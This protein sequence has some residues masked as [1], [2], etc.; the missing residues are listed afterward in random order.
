ME[1]D[2]IW[3]AQRLQKSLL[4]SVHWKSSII[5][6]QNF[7]SMLYDL[8]EQVDTLQYKLQLEF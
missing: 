1:D 4:K 7:L 3:N 6:M 8:S 2:E 5:K